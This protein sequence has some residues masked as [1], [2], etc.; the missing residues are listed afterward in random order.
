M[1]QSRKFAFI[2]HYVEPWNWLLNHRIF[3]F[4]HVHPQWRILLFPL[5]PLCWIM[6]VWYLIGR[7]PFQV[8]DTYCVNTELKGYTILINNFAWHFLFPSYHETIRKRILAATLFAQNELG[9]H[10]VGL[11]A[12]TKAETV[13]QGGVWLVEQPGVTVPIVHGDTC[14]AWFVIKRLETVA[15]EVGNRK[16]AMVGP[17]SKVG[18]AIMLYLA[19]R[20][21]TFKAYTRSIERFQEIQSELPLHLRERLMHISDLRDASSCRIWVTGKS[22]P[23]GKRLLRFIPP[24]ATVMNFAVPDPLDAAVLESRK[25]ITHIEGGLA[26]TPQSCDMRFMMRLRPH[27]TYAC[28]AGTMVHAYNRWSTCEVSEVDMNKLEP[29]GSACEALDLTLAPLQIEKPFAHD[30][31]V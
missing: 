2:A 6:S 9:V 24:G 3:G 16:V 20:G 31:A 15:K 13:T 28:T 23:D 21:F 14:T 7:K 19:G 8:V 10:V 12:L 11:G 25:D 30:E 27:I 26:K 4:L 5:F 18:R 17:T 22:K 29:I 1:N